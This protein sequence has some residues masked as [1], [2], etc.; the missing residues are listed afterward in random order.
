[1]LVVRLG[2]QPS[3]T[4]TRAHCTC[5]HAYVHSLACTLIHTGRPCEHAHTHTLCT[6]IALALITAFLVIPR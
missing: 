2:R 4:R 1:M 6:H 3:R 5:P